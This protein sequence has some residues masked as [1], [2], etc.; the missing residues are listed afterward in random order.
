[1]EGEMK[2]NNEAEE[3]ARKYLKEKDEAK[4]MAQ[5]TQAAVQKLYKEIPEVPIVVEA[6]MEEHLLKISEVIKYLC[7]RIEDLQFCST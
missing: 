6:N 7:T 3:R 1:L 4:I 5:K 2:E